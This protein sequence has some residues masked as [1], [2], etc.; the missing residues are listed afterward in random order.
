VRVTPLD[1]RRQGDLGGDRGTAHLPVRVPGASKQAQLITLAN[2]ILDRRAPR[3][4]R[5]P[6][7]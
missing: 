6:R 2:T 1:Q 5:D 3:D 7:E 4:P